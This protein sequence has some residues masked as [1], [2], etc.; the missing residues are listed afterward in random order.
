MKAEV[1]KIY[2]NKFLDVS[3]GLNKLETNVVKLNSVLVDLKK[4]KWFCRKRS[5]KKKCNILNTKVNNLENKIP[6][7]ATL[8]RIN[9]Y[10]TD[11]KFW[12]KNGKVEKKLPDG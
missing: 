2:I 5:C 11:K 1:D 8:I 10:Y 12:E 7:A 9:Q 6:D 4:I 3:T